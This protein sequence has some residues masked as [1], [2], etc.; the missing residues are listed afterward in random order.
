[1]LSENIKVKSNVDE[2]DVKT[3]RRIYIYGDI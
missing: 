3:K 1:M 2:T